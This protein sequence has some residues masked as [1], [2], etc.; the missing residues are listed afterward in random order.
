MDITIKVTYKND[1]LKEQRKAAGL[2]QS[3]L[4]DAT[5]ISYRVLQNYEQGVRDVNKAQLATLLRIC[6]SLDCR[7]SDII[8]DPDTLELLAN[9]EK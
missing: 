9:Y 8:T 7:L 1:K 2:S 3:Q 6:K 4:A 5:G